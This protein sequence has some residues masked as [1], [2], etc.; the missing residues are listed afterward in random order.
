MRVPIVVPDFQLGAE[1]VRLGEWSVEIGDA[2]DEGECV[3]EL[4]CPGIVVDLPVP[5][6]GVITEMLRQPEHL[7]RPGEVLGW[8][9]TGVAVDG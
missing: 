7:V 9:E 1:P 3:A 5:A 8:V 2:V 4:I 6:T